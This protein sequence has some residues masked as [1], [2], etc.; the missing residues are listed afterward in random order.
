MRVV[1][2]WRYPVKS[3]GGEPLQS[4]RFDV[5]G[6][7]YDRR[8]A[9]VDIDPARAGKPLTGRRQHQLLAYCSFVRGGEVYVRTP[10]GDEYP[11]REGAWL[12]GLGPDLAHP[13]PVRESDSPIHDDSD[14]LVLNAASLRVLEAEYGAFVNPLRFRPNVIVDGPDVAPFDELAWPGGEFSLGEAVLQASHH[15]ARCVLTTVDPETL[16]ADPAFL[17][18]VVQQHEGRFGIYCKVVRAGDV[19]I[20]DEW[21]TRSVPEVRA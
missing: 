8:M 20:G 11:A 16:V 1:Q 19:R 5:G 14:V 7:P 21:S 15:C 12:R 10:E 18:L 13:V 4:A 9:V 6:V 3:L 2:I 17:K